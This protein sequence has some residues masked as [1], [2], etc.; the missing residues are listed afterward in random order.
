MNTKSVLENYNLF[1]EFEKQAKLFPKKVVIQNSG[2][3][4]TNEEL[5]GHVQ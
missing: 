2:N 4:I 1:L 5:T 3:G